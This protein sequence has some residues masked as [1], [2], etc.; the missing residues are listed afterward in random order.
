MDTWPEIIS[1]EAALDEV[2]S[3]PWP[4]AVDLASRLDGDVL[5]LGATGKVGPTLVRTV[6]RALDAAGSRHQVIAV[7]RHPPESLRGEGIRLVP[8]DLTDLA[9]VERLPRT[10]HVIFLAGRKFGSSGNEALTWATNVVVPY[11][12]ARTFTGSQIVAF[13]TGCVY[14][15]MDV[16]TGGAT[17][18]TPPEPVGEY[19][20]S[21]LGRERMFDYFAQTAGERVLHFRLNYAVEL[22]YGVLVDVAAKVWAGQ[23]V[24]VTTGYANVIWQGDVANEA[25]LCLPLAAS[26]ARPLNITGAETIRIRDVAARFG[27][28]F[29][30]EAIIA[31]AEN[32]R[33]Y[34]SNAAAAHALFGPPAVSLDRMIGW[35]AHWVR[36]GGGTLNKPTHFEVQDGKY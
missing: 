36:S 19:S 33:G 2:Q 17:E 25:L 14:P 18:A 11:H 34:L 35:I 29:G 27:R 22:R 32:G 8:C 5:V 21:C 23:P 30:R 15:V 28:L 10:P 1:D 24:D 16:S 13:S 7:S 6:R 9:A 26:P 12:V 31:G 4:Q 20:M 3:R